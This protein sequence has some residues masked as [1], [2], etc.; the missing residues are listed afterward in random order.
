MNTTRY[1]NKLLAAA[2]MGITIASSAG[3]F[4]AVA[5]T[6][7]SAPENQTAGSAL[8]SAGDYRIEVIGGPRQDGGIGKL[9]QADSRSSVLVRLV[10]SSDGTL[11]TD[12]DVTLA[13]A[14]MAPDGMGEMTA[15]S[16]IRP[17]GDPGTYRVEIH[18]Q[19][20]GRWGVTV[21]AREPGASEP[22]NHTLNVALIK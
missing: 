2:A 21:A 12:A 3:A 6:A 19:M 11:L 16:Y 18:P 5:P 4:A 17:Y 8:A 9:H 14:D 22:I 15:L 10:R 7:S 13:R 20:A 1:T